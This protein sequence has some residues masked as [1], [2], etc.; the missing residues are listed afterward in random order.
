[1]L[2]NSG[3]AF[4]LFNEDVW[5]Q[6]YGSV[7]TVSATFLL[8]AAMAGVGLSTDLKKLKGLGMKPF[9]IGLIA[10]LSVSLVSFL[11]VYFFGHLISL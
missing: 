2:Q 11:L 9:F 6:L 1:M 8:G 7:S 5:Q 3:N 4:W 10:A